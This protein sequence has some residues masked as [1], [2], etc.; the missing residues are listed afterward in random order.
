VSINLD[1]LDLGPEV[2]DMAERAIQGSFRKYDPDFYKIDNPDIEG[3]EEIGFDRTNM[4]VSVSFE[5]QDD[6]YWYEVL[7]WDEDSAVVENAR[8][9]ILKSGEKVVDPI[10]YV[11]DDGETYFYD[12]QNYVKS[13]N[14]LAVR[15]FEVSEDY[16]KFL[17]TGNY[18]LIDSAIS[19]LERTE[20]AQVDV[21]QV[22]TR[23]GSPRKNEEKV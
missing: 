14:P 4:L 11:V 3:V 16:R 15:A 12:G 22:Y 19:L 13:V 23:D 6:A 9:T 8:T 20:A 18:D 21:P 2:I 1:D 5:S 10:Y 17:E 7:A